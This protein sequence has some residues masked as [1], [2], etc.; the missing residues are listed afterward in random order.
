MLPKVSQTLREMCEQISKDRE[1]EISMTD[2]ILSQYIT[3]HNDS[4]AY[5]DKD[6]AVNRLAKAIDK[7]IARLEKWEKEALAIE[8]LAD[9]FYGD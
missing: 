3:D 5:R 2:E 7:M 4:A 9:N 1:N 6:R 8:Q